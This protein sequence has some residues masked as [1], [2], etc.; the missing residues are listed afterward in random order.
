MT[1]STN[2][3][4]QQKLNRLRIPQRLETYLPKIHWALVVLRQSTDH[5][6]IT[7]KTGEPR[8]QPF[9]SIFDE[10]T[11]ERIE[12]MVKTLQVPR[13]SRS[14]LITTALELYSQVPKAGEPDRGL[15]PAALINLGEGRDDG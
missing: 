10:E 14:A 5:H 12:R 7:I 9:M 6:W 8:I 11:T 2:S 3:P 1:K 13:E 15:T 4:K